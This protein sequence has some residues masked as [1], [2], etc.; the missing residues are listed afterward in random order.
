M[1]Q[2]VFELDTEQERLLQ[3]IAAAER[4]STGDLC[5][6]LVQQFLQRRER[7]RRGQTP[8]RDREPN[9]DR[10]EA[11][12]KMIGAAKEGPTDMSINHDYR[13]GDP[14]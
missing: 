2:V 11:F 1:S 12:R 13:P 9:P 6:E 8:D 14:M 4:R 5:R 10:Y 3:E 7:S